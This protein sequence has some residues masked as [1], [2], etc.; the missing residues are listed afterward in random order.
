MLTDRLHNPRLDDAKTHISK[1]LRNSTDCPTR[2]IIESVD[3]ERYREFDKSIAS[4]GYLFADAWV[5]WELLNEGIP[6]SCEV[7][8]PWSHGVTHL[9]AV[10]PHGSDPYTGVWEIK[11]TGNKTPSATSENRRQVQRQMYLAQ[12]AGIELPDPWRIIVISKPTGAKA[13][14]RVT[15]SEK[16]QSILGAE[17]A[18][19]AKY[20]DKAIDGTL[21]TDDDELRK[22]C[23]CS[24]CYPPPLERILST[25]DGELA[26]YMDAKHEAAFAK[27][28]AD[29]LRDSIIEKVG[30]AGRFQTPNY[31]FTITKKNA[32]VGVKGAK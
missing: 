22:W 4:L 14:E 10:V 20:A 13:I 29:E 19:V 21:D 23:R 28:Q 2:R 3:P 5:Q 1:G 6:V 27:E 12:V 7:P 25:V 31:F 26:A 32:I 30:R 16:D 24:A 18:F 17:F 8:I 15:L 9:D 11:T